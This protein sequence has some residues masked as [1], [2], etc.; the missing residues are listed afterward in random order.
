M[1]DSQYKLYQWAGVLW[2]YEGFVKGVGSIVK[3]RCPNDKC[4]LNI[5]SK[6]K[7]LLSCPKCDFHI[8]LDKSYYEKE[9]DALKIIA[10]DYWKDAEVVNID[11]EVIKVGKEIIKDPDYWVKAY[12]SKSIKGVK[13]L[14]VLVG[15]KKEDDKVQLFIDIDNEKLSFDQNNRHPKE[16]L[17]KVTAEFKGSKSQMELKEEK[18]KDS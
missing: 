1:S 18:K 5:N 2:S 11:G 3:C 10:S 12:I 4:E 15:S 17:T 16:L 14:M 7:D 13:Q 6:Y 8:E 9:K